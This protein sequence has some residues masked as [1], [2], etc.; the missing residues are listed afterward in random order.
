[1]RRI[2]QD[3]LAGVLA[4]GVL[5]G[6]AAALVLWTE[7]LATIS[8]PFLHALTVVAE[9]LCGVPILLGAVHIAAQTAVR[10]FARDAGTDEADPL[11]AE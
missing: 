8:G 4:F 3:V 9:L 7:R 10:I 5:L 2:A 6:S 11:R 1:M